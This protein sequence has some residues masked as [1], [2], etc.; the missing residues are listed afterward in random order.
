M[1]HDLFKNESKC[2]SSLSIVILTLD[3][4]SSSYP[5]AFV[6]RVDDQPMLKKDLR[7]IMD[8]YKSAVT[9][10]KAD[11]LSFI[12]KAKAEVKEALLRLKIAVDENKL[13]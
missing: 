5:S 9:K 6:I 12:Q 11:L 7:S 8:D 13:S 10:A 4:V 2:I 1:L 3:V